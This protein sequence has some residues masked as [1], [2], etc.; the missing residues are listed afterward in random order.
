MANTCERKRRVGHRMSAR[1]HKSPKSISPLFAVALATDLL[2]PFLIW[3]GV[4]PAAT[5]W[6]SHAAVGTMMIGAYA[7]MMVLNRVPVVAWLIV[8]VSAIGITVALLEGQ[9]VVPTA[10]GWWMMFEYP[11]VGLFAYL[12]PRWPERFPQRLRRFC[13]AILGIQVIVQIAQ[14]LAGQPQGDDLAGIFGKNG[15]QAQ[16]VFILFV[17]CLALGQWLAQGQWRVL[18]AVL[19]LGTV[20]SVLGEIKLFPVGVIALAMLTGTLFIFRA[21]KLGKLIPYVVVFGLVVLIFTLA[22]NATI[23]AAQTRPME[24]FLE[25][26]TLDAYLNSRY[27]INTFGRYS[28]HV[29]RNFAI[30]Y[31]WNAIRRDTTTLLFGMGLGAR[32]ESRTLGTAGVGLLRGS[33]GLNSGTSLMIMM[34]ELGLVGLVVLGGF[35]FWTVVALFKAIKRYPQSDAVE[36]RYALLLFSLPWPLWLWYST[37]WIQRVSMLLYWAALGHVLGE[38]Q[39]HHLGPRQSRLASPSSRSQKEIGL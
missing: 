15:T 28:Y 33:L 11:M 19:V 2:T 30:R 31:G 7:R 35:I 3:K 14:L 6:I 25:R 22:Y 24:K 10:W 18:A 21:R 13:T 26:Q 34:Q 23:P 1:M 37:T 16:V 8:G 17:L 4:L 27:R 12:Q 39:R 9:G 32:G 29:G 38:S 36:L 20:S 5:R